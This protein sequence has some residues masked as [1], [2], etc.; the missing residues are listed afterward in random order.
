M[1]LTDNLTDSSAHNDSDNNGSA[2]AMD[3]PN[4]HPSLSLLSF[5][6]CP[7]HCSVRGF[8]LVRPRVSMVGS[9]YEKNGES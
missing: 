4:S 7:G 9:S 8:L 3:P 1:D 5:N 6:A 2:D